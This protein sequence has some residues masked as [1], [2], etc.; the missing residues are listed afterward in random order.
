M[1][2]TTTSNFR[3]LKNLETLTWSLSEGSMPMRTAEKSYCASE[4]NNGAADF[5]NPSVRLV[6]RFDEWLQNMASFGDAKAYKACKQI[7]RASVRQYLVEKSQEIEETKPEIGGGWDEQRQ[8]E[9]NIDIFNAAKA[10]FCFFLPVNFEGPTVEKSRGAV[11]KIITVCAHCPVLLG[12][13]TGLVGTLTI[14]QQDNPTDRRGG[15]N[16]VVAALRKMLRS[17]VLNL[18]S[19]TELLSHA[20]GVDRARV[21]VPNNIT[22][23]WAHLILGLLNVERSDHVERL[24]EDAIFLVTA[25]ASDLV[26]TLSQKSFKQ[27]SV[28]LPLEIFSIMS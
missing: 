20:R 28:I 18:T 9:E 11:G 7:Q 12:V 26:K 5:A 8:L 6:I 22:A 16:F 10:A 24:I 1:S 14:L 13:V 15:R 2:W 3:S 19:L 23:A 17:L 4:L 27:S 21:V 25:G